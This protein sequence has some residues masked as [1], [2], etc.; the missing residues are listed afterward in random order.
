MLSNFLFD[1]FIVSLAFLDHAFIDRIYR[2]WQNRGGTN[3]FAGTHQG[4]EVNA[5]SAM[6][7]FGRTAGGILAGISECV[8][9]VGGV[10]TVNRQLELDLLDMPLESSPAVAEAIPGPPVSEPVSAPPAP[11]DVQTAPEPLVSNSTELT[12]QNSAAGSEV[13]LDTVA[14]TSGPVTDGDNSIIPKITMAKKKGLLLMVAQKKVT[15]PVGYK[16]EVRVAV[17]MTESCKSAAE[18][19]GMAPANVE[20][21]VRTQALIDLKK[22][23]DISE[24]EVIFEAAAQVEQEGAMEVAAIQ[25]GLDAPLKAGK[26]SEFASAS[27][28]TL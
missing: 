9:Y 21:Y 12:V 11:D 8:Q 10:A 15:N 4:V 20:A 2:E 13:L 27:V 14:I 26:T 28:V 23:I 17:G 19:F 7:P 22:G 24:P 6:S 5:E 3:Q 16:E 18:K 1:L 25:A